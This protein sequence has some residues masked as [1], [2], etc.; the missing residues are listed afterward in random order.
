MNSVAVRSTPEKIAF[1][2]LLV[3]HLLA[4]VLVRADAQLAVN[5]GGHQEFHAKCPAMMPGREG[6]P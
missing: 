3:D 4:G 5:D 1:V 6:D 2:E